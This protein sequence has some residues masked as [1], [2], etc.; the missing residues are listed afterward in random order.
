MSNDNLRV[1]KASA[2][3]AY[4]SRNQRVSQ[5]VRSFPFALDFQV[6]LLTSPETSAAA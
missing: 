5:S 3:A 1:H 2:L 4:E 6:F